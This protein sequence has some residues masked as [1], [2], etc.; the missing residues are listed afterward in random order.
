MLHWQLKNKIKFIFFNI[1]MTQVV[2]SNNKWV[3]DPNSPDE[4]K[5][6]IQCPHN[7]DCV[8]VCPLQFPGYA[9]GVED[10]SGSLYNYVDCLRLSN[11]TCQ[12][13]D[14]NATST[15]WDSYNTNQPAGIKPQGNDLVTQECVYN[16]SDF[17]TYSRIVAF[18][19]KF[20][21]DDAN[22]NR[23]MVQFCASPSSD[24]STLESKCSNLK[25]TG[26][27]G[28]L[29][30]TWWASAS[31]GDKAAVGT[32]YCA[33]NNTKECACIN[34][35]ENMVYQALV[36]SSQANDCC[37]WLP[38]KN[39]DEFFV[40]STPCTT[41][42]TNVC[43][44][45]VEAFDSNNF[46]AKTIGQDIDCPGIQENS[47]PVVNI[48]WIF[49]VIIAILVVVI[50]ILVPPFRLFVAA[51]ILITILFIVLIFGS[52]GAYFIIF[53]PSSST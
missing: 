42:P 43:E 39:P 35:S 19:N 44:A 23:M 29:C 3:Q 36:K 31:D 24:C 53:N 47:T 14:L 32:N 26:A 33:A 51:H 10:T 45:V 25:D 16:L 9:T 1:K 52:I 6:E 46:N 18:R 2:T 30:R 4:L 15:S 12:I 20:P 5:S 37:W 34:R 49:P 13:G 21:K 17:N 22:Y 7:S 11:A 28:V 8:N 41:C 40:P 48:D 38:C 27:A 50:V